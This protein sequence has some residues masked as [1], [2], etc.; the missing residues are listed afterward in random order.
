MATYSRVGPTGWEQGDD[1]TT[2][3]FVKPTGWDQNN[4]AVGA[5]IV[6]PPLTTGRLLSLSGGLLIDD[7]KLL[8]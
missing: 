7:G 3:S 6:S 1:S 5:S 4:A 8:Q 2:T